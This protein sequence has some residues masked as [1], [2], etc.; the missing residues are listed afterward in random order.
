ME[1]ANHALKVI[2]PQYT[3]LTSKP[4]LQ[5]HDEVERFILEEMPEKIE[6]VRKL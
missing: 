3:D 2:F 1:A 4:S 6:M 5:T